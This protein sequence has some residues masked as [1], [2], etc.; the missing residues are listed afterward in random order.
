MRVCMEALPHRQTTKRCWISKFSH[1]FNVEARSFKPVNTIL[2][3][4][5]GIYRG[6]GG[7]F[8]FWG[9]GPIPFNPKQFFIEF[10]AKTAEN[11]RIWAGKQVR[12]YQNLFFTIFR[13]IS[14]YFVIYH[15]NSWY[16]MR[17]SSYFM[18]IHDNSLWFMIIH[19]N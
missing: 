2:P 6:Y 13:D 16:F 11:G 14:W 7:I 5:K 1:I 15:E 18:I 17:T 9:L 10:A 3:L 12:L 19:Y 4:I 8:Y